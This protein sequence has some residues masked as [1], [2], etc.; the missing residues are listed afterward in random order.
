MNKPN[1]APLIQPEESE[2]SSSTDK[3]L[4]SNAVME[5]FSIVE[6]ED[7]LEFFYWCNG[8]CGCGGEE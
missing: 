6:L 8:D 1:H 3:L 7:R 5:E 2:S 4:D